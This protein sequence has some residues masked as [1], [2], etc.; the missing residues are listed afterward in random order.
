MDN[1]VTNIYLVDQNGQIITIY[2]EQKGNTSALSFA[3]KN[4]FLNVKEKKTNHLTGVTTSLLTK[5][6]TSCIAEPLFRP[7]GQFAGMIGMELSFNKA[8]EIIQKR[9]TWIILIFYLIRTRILLLR[10][11]QKC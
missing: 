3:N 7:D 1:A 2:P 10:I 8:Q 4:C 9:A 6:T 5:K 11:N